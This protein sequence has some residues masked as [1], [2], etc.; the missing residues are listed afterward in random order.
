MAFTHYR[1]YGFVFKKENK[2]EADRLFTIFTFEY[3]RIQVLGRAIRKITSKLK[4]GIDLFY[5]VEVEFIQG[6]GYKTLTDVSIIKKY[7]FLEKDLGKLK[8]ALSISEILNSFIFFQEKDE[9]ILDLII[10]SFEKLDEAFC[11]DY[12]FYYFFWNLFSILGY[13]PQ[14]YNC[15]L[16]E[17][18]LTPKSLFFSPE[19]GGVIC[20]KC[21]KEGI[22][23]SPELIKILRIILKKDWDIF[24]KLKINFNQKK[25][26]MKISANYRFYLLNFFCQYDKIE[27]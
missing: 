27:E 6:K 24:L 26:L 23:V 2:G 16:C 14:L 7:K 5:L 3:G 12:L 9:R 15:S 11:N 20:E 10:E 25:E 18:K 8:T 21:N 17:N 4:G 19:E 1:T 13:E 22:K